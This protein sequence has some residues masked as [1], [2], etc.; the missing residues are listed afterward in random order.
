MLIRGLAAKGLTTRN[1]RHYLFIYQRS[2][3][4]T[5]TTLYG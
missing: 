1:F 2:R 5:G 3:I 4:T